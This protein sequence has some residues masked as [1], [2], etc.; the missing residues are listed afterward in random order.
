MIEILRS[1]GGE[2]YSIEIHYIHLKIM[3]YIKIILHQ[4]RKFNKK[5]EIPFTYSDIIVDSD[6]SDI[7]VDFN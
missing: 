2:I 1:N 4:Q 6:S 5:N 7:I 3:F